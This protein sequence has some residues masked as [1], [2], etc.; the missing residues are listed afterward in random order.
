MRTLLA[1]ITG[2]ALCLAPAACRTI[3]QQAEAAHRDTHEAPLAQ[4]ASFRVL[5]FNIRYGT[6]DDGANSWERRKDLVAEVLV[7]TAPHLVS[8]QEALDF[9]LDY[10]LER[11]PPFEKIGQHREGG[12]KGEFCGLLVDKQRFR[13][14]DSGEFWLSQSPDEPGS[15]GWDAAC[16]RMCVWAHLMDRHSGRDLVA[17][18]THLDHKG[19][20]A[21]RESVGQIVHHIVDDR[22]RR[23]VPTLLA[24]DFNAGESSAPLAFLENAGFS[25]TYRMIWPDAGRR[26]TFN[27][28]RGR[29]DGDKI[30]Y[31]LCSRG[32]RILDAAIIKTQRNGRYPSDHFPVLAVVEVL[33]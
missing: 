12:A 13:V 7:D 15:I 31:I 28:F 9:Q 21:R 17:F 19:T 26:G 23:T 14:L 3:A 33:P 16:P 25:D 4:R 18:S 27:A 5:T 32:F 20:R 1:L 29:D 24:G 10:L 11:L 6:A 22:M 2:L 30:D 8:I